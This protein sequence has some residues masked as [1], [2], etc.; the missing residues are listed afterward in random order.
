MTSSAGES[1][2]AAGRVGVEFM[3]PAISSDNLV[4]MGELPETGTE[5]FVA[6]LQGKNPHVEWFDSSHWGYAVVEVGRDELTYS[7]YAV[8]RTVDA[9]DA[10]RELLRR[11]RVPAGTVKMERVDES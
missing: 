3:A 7:A 1:V 6:G 8:D 11:Y 4:E 5:V 10:P 9:T 2:D